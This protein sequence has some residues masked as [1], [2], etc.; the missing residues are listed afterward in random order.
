MRSDTDLPTPLRPRMQ[1]VW[2]RSTEKLTSS[3]T[4]RPSNEMET[5]LKDNDR[6]RMVVAV[7]RTG[8]R[9][10]SSVQLRFDELL[11][12]RHP[13]PGNPDS[14]KFEHACDQLTRPAADR[15]IGARK[16]FRSIHIE[17]PPG[18]GQAVRMSDLPGLDQHLDRQA[19]SSFSPS[20]GRR[21]L[22]R[23]EAAAVPGCSSRSSTGSAARSS[24]TG[25]VCGNPL[26]EANGDRRARD[27]RMIEQI[28]EQRRRAAGQVDGQKN[29]PLPRRRPEAERRADSAQRAQVRLDIRN[30]R[31]Q[32]RKRRAAR[33]QSKPSARHRAECR[34]HGRPAAG[35]PT[36]PGPCPRP[37]GW[38]ARRPAQIRPRSAGLARRFGLN[39]PSPPGS[40]SA[41]RCPARSSSGGTSRWAHA[42][43][44]RAGRS[45]S[46]RWAGPGDGQSRP[47][48]ES[49]RP[50]G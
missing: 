24:T 48:S 23:R 29:R 12:G 16:I 47:R 41:T 9:A 40:G 4:A 13:R 27:P 10:S 28:T 30:H 33:R 35:R 15:G 7:A 44:R 43:C 26:T 22:E 45:P 34:A 5:W 6:L 17:E 11:L 20:C 18:R 31:A 50:S 3:R 36:P 39:R 37:C 49:I 14:R 2:P 19:P 21:G 32:S 46:S 42:D 8:R 38:T 25:K 1:S